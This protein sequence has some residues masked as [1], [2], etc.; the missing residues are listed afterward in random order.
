MLNTKLWLPTLLPAGL[1]GGY[2]LAVSDLYSEGGMPGLQGPEPQPAIL[3]SVAE[4]DD[5]LDMATGTAER[6]SAPEPERI[7][8]HFPETWLWDAF[9]LGFVFY[10]LDCLNFISL[11]GLHAKSGDSGLNTLQ[12]RTF[13]IEDLLFVYKK[14]RKI[15]MFFH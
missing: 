7:R 9:E 2:F 12:P 13:Y 8:S 3:E 15:Y 5:G 4:A 1:G 6:E 11:H 10:I 14:I